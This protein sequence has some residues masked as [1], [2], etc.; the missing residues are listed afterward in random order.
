MVKIS[1]LAPAYRIALT[2][3]RL[4]PVGGSHFTGGP[5]WPMNFGVVRQDRGEA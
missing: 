4:N 5:L 3:R 2:G 1:R